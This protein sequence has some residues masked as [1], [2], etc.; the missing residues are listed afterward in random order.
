MLPA[1]LHVAISPALVRTLLSIAL[2]FAVGA[3]AVACTKRLWGPAAAAIFWGGLVGVLQYWFQGRSTAGT[4]GIELSP[5]GL[6]L[7]FG[8]LVGG[9]LLLQQAYRCGISPARAWVR[10]GVTVASGLLSARLGYLILNPRRAESVFDWLN[11]GHGGLSG[12]GAFW[13]GTFA[14][15]L[16]MRREF[17]EY[18]RWLDLSVLPL[19][20]GAGITRIG[21]YLSGCDFG[22]PLRSAAHPFITWLGTFPRWQPNAG[23]YVV[24]SPV[25]VDQVLHWGLSPDAPCSLPVHPVQLYDAILAFALALLAL[26]LKRRRHPDGTL[27]AMTGI[28]YSLGYLLLGTLRGDTERIRLTLRRFQYSMSLGSHEQLL[29]LGAVLMLWAVHWSWLREQPLIARFWATFSERSNHRS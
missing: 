23:G 5:A 16:L 4:F 20:L 18:R 3:G 24:G 25:W 28:L 9:S 19:L 29:A 14:L 7:A 6:A 21:C 1:E 2:I 22:R 11:F 15:S 13:G 17:A 8:M 27:F 12:F 10:I 26:L